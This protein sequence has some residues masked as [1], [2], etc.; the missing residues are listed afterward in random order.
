MRDITVQDKTLESRILQAQ[1]INPS[2][3]VMGSST[4]YCI[5]LQQMY[6]HKTARPDNAKHSL[7]AKQ[8]PRH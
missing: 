1:A 2:S 6:L 4:V 8:N 7:P 5:P 3:G